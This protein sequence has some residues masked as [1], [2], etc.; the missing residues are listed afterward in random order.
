MGTENKLAHFLWCGM[1]GI[2][3]LEWNRMVGIEWLESL[4]PQKIIK[5]HA[6]VKSWIFLFLT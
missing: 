3:W 2:E 5:W 6:H 4:N 1:V